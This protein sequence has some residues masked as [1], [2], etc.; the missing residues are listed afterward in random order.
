MEGTVIYI[1]A[2]G[3]KTIIKFPFGN[4]FNVVEGS[5]VVKCEDSL[6]V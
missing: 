2:E 6:I 1:R 3:D 4:K 5:I